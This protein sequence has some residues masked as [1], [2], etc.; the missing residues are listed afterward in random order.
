MSNPLRIRH[1]DTLPEG[2]LEAG[3]ADLNALLGGPCLIHLQG[4]REAPLFVSCL[5]HGNEDTGFEAIKRLLSKYQGQTLP[6]SL[7]ILIG[8]VS[9]AEQGLRRLDGQPD[10]NR[11][12][13]GGELG[14]SAEGRMMAEVYRSMA[15][16]KVFA[17]IDIHNNTGLNPHY[18]C[19]NRLDDHFF[20]LATLFSRTVVYFIRPTGVAST[21]MA[22]LCPSVTVECGQPGNEGSVSHTAEYVDAA[23]HL[24]D[25]PTHAMAEHDMDLFH[26]VATVKVPEEVSFHFGSTLADIQFDPDLDHMNFR[27]LPPGVSFGRVS[28]GRVTRERELPIQAWNERGEQ[29][30]QTYFQLDHGHLRTRRSVMPSMLTL[31]ER[32]IRQD[33]LCYLMERVPVMDWRR[34]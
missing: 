32:V 23:L 14:D 30:A 12:W 5:L 13:P 15:Q 3:A 21:A 17:S 22:Q 19:V 6:R 34:H 33:C 20:H 9:A 24:A 26:T 25:L 2:L 29:V 10:Y 27:E 16:R 18:A 28:F 31:D 11:V 4:R 1:V 7:S 8:N